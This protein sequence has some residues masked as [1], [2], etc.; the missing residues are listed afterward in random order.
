MGNGGFNFD[1]KLRRQSV[2]RTDLFHG[3]IG[4][5][6]ALALALLVAAEMIA[7]GT[8]TGAR[9]SRYAGWSEELGSRIMEGT[10]TLQSL[11]ERVLAGGVDPA[12]ASGG[13]EVLENEVNRAL[14]RVR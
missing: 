10:E 3:H 12:P 13:Q 6:D 14:W 11:A 9:Q 8:L 4:G 7:D 1:A 2:N 5:L